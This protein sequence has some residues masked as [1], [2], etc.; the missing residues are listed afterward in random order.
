MYSRCVVGRRNQ[1]T[2]ERR[3]I[4][5]RIQSGTLVAIVLC[6]LLSACATSGTRVTSSSDAYKS[7]AQT[8]QGWCSKV[9]GCGCTVDG[10]PAT[11]SLVAMCLNSGSCQRATQ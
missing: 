7:M 2:S 6:A 3:S 8:Q 10:Q 1:G 11:C 4:M 5:K 9:G